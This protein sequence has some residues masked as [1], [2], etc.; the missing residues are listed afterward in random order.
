LKWIKRSKKKA[1]ELAK[2]REE[3]LDAL[4]KAIQEEYTESGYYFTESI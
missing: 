2:K 3:E 4:D 1:K